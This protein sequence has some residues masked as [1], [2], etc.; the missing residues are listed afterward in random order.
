MAKPVAATAVAKAVWNESPSVW[1]CARGGP[2]T[3]IIYI[4]ICV[5]KYILHIHTR[6]IYIYTHIHT[7]IY[8][9]STTIQSG[10]ARV[11]G[12]TRD[13]AV[14]AARGSKRQPE[15]P[16]SAL[17]QTKNAKED[18]FAPHSRATPPGGPARPGCGG[19]GPRPSPPR[20]THPCTQARQARRCS[21]GCA[22]PS[23]LRIL[24]PHSGSAA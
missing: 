6:H 2:N 8:T 14:T 23:L 13:G 20:R 11:G 3:Y 7:Y 21:S 22:G 12:Q 1:T 5:Y 4:Y 19:P 9:C 17:M 16:S 10:P 18:S 15:R 24:E